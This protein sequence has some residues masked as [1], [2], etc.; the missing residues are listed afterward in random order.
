MVTKRGDYLL[1]EMTSLS[2][3]GMRAS[4]LSRQVGMVVLLVFLSTAQDQVQEWSMNRLV[5]FFD[6]ATG[7]GGN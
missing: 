5:A 1:A 2:V 3:P 4:E 7:T 6:Q